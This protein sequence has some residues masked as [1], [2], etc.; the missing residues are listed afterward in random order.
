MGFKKKLAGKY[1]KYN[2]IYFRVFDNRYGRLFVKMLEVKDKKITIQE[3]MTIELGTAIS[4]NAKEIT[5]KT[6]IAEL[7]LLGL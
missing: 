1:F 4:E 3:R 6:K 2:N 5:N 7:I